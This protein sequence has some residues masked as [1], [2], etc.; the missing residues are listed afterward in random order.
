MRTVRI[1]ASECQDLGKVFMDKLDEYVI[2][3]YN[4]IVDLISITFKKYFFCGSP[5]SGE[6]K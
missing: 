6:D 3:R 4:R 1:L 2:S 5:P